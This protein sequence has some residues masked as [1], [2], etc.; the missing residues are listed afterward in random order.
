MI[1][2]HKDEAFAVYNFMIS[3]LRLDGLDL[4]LY[5]M[6]YRRENEG[7]RSVLLEDYKTIELLTGA[8]AFDTKQALGRLVKRGYLLK[9]RLSPRQK[10]EFDILESDG[11]DWGYTVDMDTLRLV[12]G[13]TYAR[14][15]YGE[16]LSIYPLIKFSE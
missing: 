5:A 12:N 1:H 4:L 10:V 13:K 11:I 9:F 7:K 16:R 8:S 6:A 15:T 3:D 2:E 14:P